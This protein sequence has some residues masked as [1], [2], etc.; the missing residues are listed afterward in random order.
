VGKPFAQTIGNLG[1]VAT[2]IGLIYFSSAQPS[3]LVKVLLWLL[4][5]L[6]LWVIGR[7]WHWYFGHRP[8]EY[9]LQSPS[10]VA[11]LCTWLSSGGRAA[12]F[13]RDLSWVTNGS[14]AETILRRK[15]ANGE[16]VVFVGRRTPLIAALA[17]EGASI[18]DYSSLDFNPTA[19]FTIVDLGRAGARMA[20]GLTKEGKHV[21][22]EYDADDHAIM[23]LAA[24]LV[25]LAERTN[26]IVR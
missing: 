14:Q 26:P 8:R 23:A 12:V 22:W 20:I 13:S 9:A 2:V 6:A 21:I 16:L 1:T 15:A 5:A 10:I 25:A 24:D 4:I 17:A 3:S 11:Y 18:H 19:R 7:E